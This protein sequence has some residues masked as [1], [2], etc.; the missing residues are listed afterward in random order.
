MDCNDLVL[1]FFFKNNGLVTVIYVAINW[2]TWKNE[3]ETVEK[4][5]MW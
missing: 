5:N 2:L 3:I 1:R 4:A